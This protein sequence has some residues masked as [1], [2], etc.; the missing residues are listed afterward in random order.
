MRRLKWNGW[1]KVLLYLFE[2][3]NMPSI[4]STQSVILFVQTLIK[5]K[6][7]L[8]PYRPPVRC[9][10]IVLGNENVQ[11][12]SPFK[13]RQESLFSAMLSQK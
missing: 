3:N 7:V 2:L 4:H 9:Q 8:F 13:L 6:I 12:V 5:K 1:R 11:N 10:F